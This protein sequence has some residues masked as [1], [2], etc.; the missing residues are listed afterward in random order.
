MFGAPAMFL[1]MSQ[2]PEFADTDL[3][4]ISTLICGAAPVP[5]SLIELYAAR[6]VPFCQ[7]YGLTETAPFSAFLTP[8]WGVSKLGSAGQPPLYSDTGSSM[9]TTRNWRRVS[10]ARSAC[11]ARTS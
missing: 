5:E 4:S 1:F 8:E 11:A 9:T 2:Q 3:S 10:A 7:G 6:D